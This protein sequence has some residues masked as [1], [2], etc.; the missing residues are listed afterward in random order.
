[1]ENHVSAW[2][3]SSRTN[4]GKSLSRAARALLTVGGLMRP[5]QSGVADREDSFPQK[6]QHFFHFFPEA[7]ECRGMRVAEIGGGNG[8]LSAFFARHG[9][10]SVFCIEPNVERADEAMERAKEYS[11]MRVRNSVGEDASLPSASFDRVVLHDVMEHCNDPV[12]VLAEAG[13]ILTSAGDM[14]V[15]FVPWYAPYG[16]HTW[17]T[18]PLPWGHLFYPKS[19]LAEMRSHKSGWHTTDLG[20]TGLYKISIRDFKKCAEA[21][22]MRVREIRYLGVKKQQ[23]LTKFP[24]LREFGTA[25]V[26]AVLQR[27]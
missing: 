18:L 16:G 8:E 14:L 5:H 20:A 9:A 24:V 27:S 3:R 1:M 6:Y 11:A 26:G 4:D 2:E 23:W 21:A 13:R 22:G 12:G 7:A 17:S 19:V 25:I 15:S 10:S